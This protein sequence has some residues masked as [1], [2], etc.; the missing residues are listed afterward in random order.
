MKLK[1]LPRLLLFIPLI[2]LLFSCGTNTVAGS[3]DTAR[4]DSAAPKENIVRGLTYA[5]FIS[6][7][8]VTAPFDTL[9]PAMWKLWKTESWNVLDTIV[10]KNNISGG[11][12]PANGFVN[13]DTITLPVDKMLDRYG[14]LYGNFL[15][16][17][18]ASFGGRS[19]PASS[20]DRVYYKFKVI[21]PIPNVLA[22]KAIPWFGQPGMGMQYM[23]PNKINVL[24]ANN[25]LIIT[26]SVPAKPV[27]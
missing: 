1:S 8:Q 24:I 10:T 19:L 16:D 15:A 2:A 18:G 9:L 27:N 21:K 11:Y 7:T 22:G 12:P 23:V 25:Y 4:K 13:V 20:R 5:S 17:D 6:M 3:N 26:D 14:S